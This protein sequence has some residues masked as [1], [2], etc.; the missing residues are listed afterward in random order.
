MLASLYTWLYNETKKELHLKTVETIFNSFYL[1]LKKGDF[2]E[3]TSY[4][5]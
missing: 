3:N 5:I 1:L 4:G 2:V